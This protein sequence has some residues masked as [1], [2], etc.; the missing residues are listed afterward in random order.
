[1]TEKEKQIQNILNTLSAKLGESPE[2][3][4]A[5]AQN[6]DISKILDKMD[7]KQ[8]QQVQ[9]ILNDK[10]KT[11]KILNTPQAQSLIKKLM[12]DN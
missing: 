8:A 3:L 12:G 4:K 10:E 5:N 7:S 11:E 2:K 1:M 9:N 6:G